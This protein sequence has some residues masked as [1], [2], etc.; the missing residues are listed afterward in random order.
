MKKGSKY[1]VGTGGRAH[2]VAKSVALVPGP[3]NYDSSLIDKKA[4][5][6][7]GFGSGGRD[8]LSTLRVPGPGQYNITARVGNEGP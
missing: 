4:S 2:V 3:G 6:R 5:P 8:G 1:S 7:Y